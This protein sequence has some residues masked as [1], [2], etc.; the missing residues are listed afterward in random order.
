MET[1]LGRCG[2]VFE[3]TNLGRILGQMHLVIYLKRLIWR[4]QSGGKSW[5]DAFDNL[6]LGDEGEVDLRR[7]IYG[8]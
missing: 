1:N 5:A 4:G 3:K 7:S 6:F 8:G 2:D